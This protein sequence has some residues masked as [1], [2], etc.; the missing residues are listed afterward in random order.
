MSDPYSTT[1]SY[2]WADRPS[3]PGSYEALQSRRKI[4][5]ALASK[6]S[7]YPKNFGEGLTSVGESI[8]DIAAQR[9]LDRRDAARTA[10]LGK[11]A[12]DAYRPVVAADNEPTD[13]TP[14][15]SAPIRTAALTPSTAT[16][17]PAAPNPV[18]DG[19][20]QV[21]TP[22]AGGGRLGL[23]QSVEFGS[24]PVAPAGPVG[25]APSRFGPSIT[26][27]AT[28]ATLAVPEQPPPNRFST[29]FGPLPN[30]PN[31]VAQPNA[32]DFVPTTAPQRMAALTGGGAPPTMTDIPSAPAGAAPAARINDAFT[33]IPSAPPAPMAAPTQTASQDAYQPIV[34]RP[35][36]EAVELYVPDPKPPRPTPQSQRELQALQR[37]AA[38]PGDPDVQR[39]WLPI[40]QQEAAK[41]TFADKAI[42]QQYQAQLARVTTAKAANQVAA[43]EAADKELERRGKE[44][45]LPRLPQPGATP[46]VQTRFG[47]V[48]TRLGT[49][50]S[51]QRNG[52]PDAE[53][54]PPWAI[55]KEWAA[56][57]TKKQNA[58]I[59]ANDKAN[60]QFTQMIDLIQQANAHP[61]RHSA[62]G[63]FGKAASLVPGT[64]AYGYAQ[65]LDQIK[66]KNFLSAYDTLRGAGQISNVEGEKSAQAQ[67][68]LSQAQSKEDFQKALNDFELTVRNDF[69]RIQRKAHVP[70]TAWQLGRDDKPAPD[71]GQLDT[72]FADG[73]ARR[74]RGGNPRDPSSWQMLR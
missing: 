48:D 60:P 44:Q 52:V 61:G 5:E 39:I 70:V 16:D 36:T 3:G 55:P 19:I 10:A 7:P 53:P 62:V 63:F 29:A 22:R 47:P 51:P 26:N 57:Q 23:D 20:A 35:P 58:V 6:R 38:F 12:T 34:P 59:E 21:M 13:E 56:L 42:D 28:G 11:E 30:V 64:E 45:D 65:L 67:A 74:Y 46:I 66:N 9:D 17:E 54:V 27:P 41:R 25:N 24:G 14:P 37:M 73:V 15:A 33:A 40:A 32:P 8:Y 50:A 18:R 72:S 1:P 31:V 4:A 2:F 49:E 68:R 43:R 69:D 71:I